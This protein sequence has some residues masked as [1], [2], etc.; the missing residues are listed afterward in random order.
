MREFMIA[1]L[2]PVPPEIFKAAMEYRD[3]K[4]GETL[5]S[6]PGITVRTAPLN[7]PDGATGYRIEYGGKSLCYITDTEHVPGSPDKNV[8]GL[9]Q[10]ADVVV[11]D[12]MYTDEEYA[13]S[14]VGWGH[15]TWQEGVRLAKLAKTKKLVIFHHD[16]EHDDDKL[17]AIAREAEAALPGTVVAREGLTVAL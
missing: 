14:Y 7:H 5:P 10:D 9:M 12:C 15:S 3:F 11:Y 2:F 16:P 13:K 4:A 6:A 17:D 8:L 1:P